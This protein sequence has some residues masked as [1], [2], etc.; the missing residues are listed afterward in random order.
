M[1]TDVR[2]Q[3]RQLTAAFDLFVDEVTADEAIRRLEMQAVRSELE[4]RRA[5]SRRANRAEWSR[6]GV[7]AAAVTLVVGLVVALVW[8]DR[9]GSDP[10]SAPPTP[11]STPPTAAAAS[12]G[13]FVWP[14]P[15]RQYETP[16]DLIAAFASEVL[17]WPEFELDG[18]VN[19]QAQPQ[20]FALSNSALDASVAAVAIPS[21]EDGWG[22][23]QIGADLTA[24]ADGSAVVLEF[25]APTM[26]A[27]SSITVRLSNGTIVETTSASGQAVLPDVELRQVVSALVIGFDGDANAVAVAGGQF[28]ADMPTVS[29]PVTDST[30]PATTTTLAG[31]ALP[32]SRGPLDYATTERWLPLWPE[33]NASDPAATTTGYGMDLCDSG[34]G[35]KILRVESATAPAH[36][37]SGTL[38]VFI[39]LAE[40][41]PAATTTCATSTERYNYARCQ[42][43]TEQTDD[44]GA[45]TAVSTTAGDEQQAAMAAFPAPTAWDQPEVFDAT[46]SAATR[47]DTSVDYLDDDVA[48]TLLTAVPT[49]DGVDDPGVCFVMELPGATV[50]GCVDR[51]L[52]ATGLAY[53]AFQ[54]GD[55]P[56]ELVGIVPDDVTSVQI[57]GRTITPENNVWHHTAADGGTALRIIVQSTDGRTASTG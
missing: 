51:P 33:V 28:T 54:D 16:S 47:S 57:D 26:V 27:S 14:A 43:R 53:G 55:G 48:V 29:A 22:F 1:S 5:P 45:G 13:Q 39:E 31:Q 34:Y 25:P 3:V 10:V 15:P 52:L 32:E 21:P 37:Y 12:L 40:P 49:T 44:A 56:I 17:G 2:E 42:R 23:V 41:R 35:T 8:V 7:A 50:D 24:T 4:R 6:F 30:P 18:D 46:V 20:S 36:A 9:D 11:T 19:E 38:C